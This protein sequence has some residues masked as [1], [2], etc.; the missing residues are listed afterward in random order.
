MLVISEHFS[1]QEEKLLDNVRLVE[2]LQADSLS[3]VELVMAL[4]H[5]FSLE[6]HDD[7]IATISTI[8]DIMSLVSKLVEEER[9]GRV[10]ALPR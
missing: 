10:Y 4:E 5:E 7:D 6:I 3:R 8:G 9:R 1:L 2:D